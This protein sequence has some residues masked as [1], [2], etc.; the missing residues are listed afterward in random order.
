MSNTFYPQKVGYYMPFLH[1]T[2]IHFG[3]QDIP[4][5]LK[6]LL[7]FLYIIFLV[8]HFNFVCLFRVVY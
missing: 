4:F 1:T 6:L 7:V 2:H 3:L 5:K 8:L